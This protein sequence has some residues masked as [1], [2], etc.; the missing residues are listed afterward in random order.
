MIKFKIDFLFYILSSKTFR[1]A[2]KYF[3]RYHIHKFVDRADKKWDDK[4]MEAL[5]EIFDYKG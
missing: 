5:D 4:M 3:F 2:Y 1:L